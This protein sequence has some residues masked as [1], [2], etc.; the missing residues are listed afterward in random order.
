MESHHNLNYFLAGSSDTASSLAH[1]SL[2][3][4]GQATELIQYK[5]KTDGQLTNCYFDPYGSKFAASD[6]LGNLF[7]WK[8]EASAASLNPC[9]TL[10]ECHVGSI[11][12]FVFLNSSSLIA[13]A[14]I[15]TNQTFFMIN[16]VMFAFG[17]HFYHLKRKKLTVLRF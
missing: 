9:I 12:D 4:F 1:I 16:S 5:V 14:G 15:A 11:T 6:T 8:F 7:V 3:Q 13:T 2:F 17:I 10:S